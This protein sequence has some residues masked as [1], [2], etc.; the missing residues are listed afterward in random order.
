MQPKIEWHTQTE[1]IG[2]Y[3][4]KGLYSQW[5]CDNFLFLN[6]KCFSG[7]DFDHRLVASDRGNLEP[8]R[9][10]VV[11][12]AKNGERKFVRKKIVRMVSRATK[13]ISR[14][15]VLR[16]IIKIMLE[17]CVEF[18]K[19]LF[20]VIFCQENIVEMENYCSCLNWYSKCFSI[21]PKNQQIAVFTNHVKVKGCY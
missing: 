18:F 2:Q 20:R 10:E 19:T 4:N 6:F 16:K 14:S 11:E 1:L 12:Q 13:R 7:P 9:P 17:F 15:Q 3:I 5:P 8:D 21:D